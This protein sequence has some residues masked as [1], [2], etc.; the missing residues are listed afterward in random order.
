MWFLTTDRNIFVQLGTHLLAVNSLKPYPTWARLKPRIERAFRAVV[1]TV[2]VT[3]LERTGLRYINRIEIP[4]EF[5]KPD[6]YQIDFDQYF[7]FRPHL[8]HNLPQTMT[9]FIVGSVLDVGKPGDRCRVQLTNAVRDRPNVAAFI[10]DLDY[11]LAERE[12]V[13][14]DRALEWVE[15]A[16]QQVEAIFEGCVSDRLRAIFGEEK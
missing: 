6:D 13:A 8:G 9:D 15:N 7:E 2:E 4:G 14:V 10:L 12:A 1:E 5:E 16:H 3:G 11:F